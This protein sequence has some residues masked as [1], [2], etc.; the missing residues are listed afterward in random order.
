MKL[1][2]TT[3]EQETYLLTLNKAIWPL[4]GFLEQWFPQMGCASESK[5]RYFTIQILGPPLTR[6]FDTQIWDRT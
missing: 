6:Y 1:S 2:I 3:V 4:T 5:K